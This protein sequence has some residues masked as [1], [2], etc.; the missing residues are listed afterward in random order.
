MHEEIPE[1]GLEMGGPDPKEEE[2]QR[3]KTSC[4]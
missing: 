4:A 3:Q 2:N 1:K